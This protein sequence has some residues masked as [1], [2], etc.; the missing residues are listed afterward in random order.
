MGGSSS[1]HQG[2]LMS[3]EEFDWETH[4][5][6]S[7]A[8]PVGGACVYVLLI[9]VI[10][11]VVGKLSPLPSAW[12]SLMTAVQAVH[13]LWMSALSLGL[14][15]YTLVEVWSRVKAEGGEWE[16]ILCEREET[17]TNGPLFYVV[18]LFYLSKFVEFFDTYAQLLKGRRIPAFRFHVIHHALTALMCW[19]WL[20]F[21][22]SLQFIG[23]GFNALV[24]VV[25]YLYYFLVTIGK[26]PWWKRLVTQVQIVQFVTSFVCLVAFYYLWLVKGR[27]CA[28]RGYAMTYNAAFN[29]FLLS[30]FLGID[31]RIRSGAK[32]DK[33]KQV[34]EKKGR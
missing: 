19:N 2:V 12:L 15:V 26:P 18:F 4:P 6:N 31:S 1:S 20:T 28:G 27:A 29:A 32:T 24:H 9:G 21:K 16:W 23:M 17:E 30:G 5:L 8:L 25:M 11:W 10:E 7:V 14:L 22:Q 3:P 13:N 34:V 33:K